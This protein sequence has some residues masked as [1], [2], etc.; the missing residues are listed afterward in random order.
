MNSLPLELLFE[1]GNWLDPK[2]LFNLSLVNRHLRTIIPN[3]GHFYTTKD[4][5]V[6]KELV[7]FQQEEGHHHFSRIDGIEK[8]SVGYPLG[9]RYG[10]RLQG[11][12]T[13][14]S[15]AWFGVQQQQWDGF[16]KYQV[17]YFEVTVIKGSCPMRIG[18]VQHSWDKSR[19]PGSLPG[20]IGYCSDDGDIS[21]GSIY[22]ER[23]LFGPKW[24]EGDTIGCGY[25]KFNSTGRIF[26]TKNGVWVGDSPE[27]VDTDHLDWTKRWHCAFSASSNGTVSIHF[28]NFKYLVKNGIAPFLTDRYEVPCSLSLPKY[29]FHSTNYCKVMNDDD[30]EWELDFKGVQE[31]RSI[32]ANIPISFDSCGYSYYKI[33]VLEKS[34]NPNAFLSIG[35][36]YRPYSSHHHIGWNSGSIGFHSDDGHVFENSYNSNLKIS[37]GFSTGDVV[38]CGYHHG[39]QTISFTQNGVV[40]LCGHKM[41]ISAPLYISIA[42]TH[43][44]KVSVSSQ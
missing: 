9:R 17:L 4:V 16:E 44:W 25:Y 7:Q 19:P 22:D 31:A 14:V 30:T 39:L 10:V 3:L 42:A 34:S 29:L 32:Q 12:R 38:V 2:S 6:K 36:A 28:N 24:G 20:S 40:R 5:L 26:F 21:I 11:D 23:F 33:K 41:D 13:V 27:R 43:A 35:F 1:I 18:L 37:C 8:P 15:K